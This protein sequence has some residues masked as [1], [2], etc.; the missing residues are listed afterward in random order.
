MKGSRNRAK[1]KLV[2]ARGHEQI[3][4]RRKDFLNKLS[5]GLIDENQVICLENLNVAGM[6]RNRKTAKSVSD[7]GWSELIRQLEYKAEW[8]GRTIVRVDRWFP[9]SQ[10]CSACGFRNPLVKD[11][12]VRE[13]VCP[14]CGVEHDRDGNAATNILAEGLRILAQDT[15][16]MTEIHACGENVRP[17]ILRRISVKQ[18]ARELIRE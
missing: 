7:A 13:W 14:A 16:G 17:E 2:V 1:Q 5:S 8:Y 9:S 10:L 4:N 11:L 6:K 3:A 15:V 12:S 18:E